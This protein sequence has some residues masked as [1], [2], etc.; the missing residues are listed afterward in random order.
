MLVD[1]SRRRSG[2]D[3]SGLAD[4]AA[5]A[6]RAE[7]LGFDAWWPRGYGEPTERVG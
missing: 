4:I 2:T 7:L 6:P 3:G 5:D 1:T